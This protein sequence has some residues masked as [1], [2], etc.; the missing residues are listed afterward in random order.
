MRKLAIMGTSGFAGEVLDLVE[1]GGRYDVELFLGN[2]DRTK[3]ERPL[4][5]R[6]VVW[7]DDARRYAETHEVICCLG[8]TPR[9]RG[10][11]RE[12]SA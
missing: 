3:T 9:S 4:F 12:P 11:S 8:T 10:N 2:W 1:D 7:I 6:P 5:G